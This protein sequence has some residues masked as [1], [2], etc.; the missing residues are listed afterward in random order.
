MTSHSRKASISGCLASTDCKTSTT[1]P[2]ACNHRTGVSTS[3]RRRI[4]EE[5]WVPT[6]NGCDLAGSGRRQTRLPRLCTR[7][8]E[9]TC[10]G[11]ESVVVGGERG[12]LRL[13]DLQ[14]ALLSH[15]ATSV[16]AAQHLGR[17][18]DG[19]RKPPGLFS[20]A[21]LTS[22]SAPS[23]GRRLTRLEVGYENRSRLWLRGSV[24]AQPEQLRDL[25]D[26]RH[27]GIAAGA[28]IFDTT[29]RG[30]FNRCRPVATP[31]RIS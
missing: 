26:Q 30:A 24:V 9:S 27:A 4:A 19:G 31:M 22:V 1:T 8:P 17:S 10:A 7:A 25:A 21:C 3:S 11:A 15:R 12:G 6:P 2:S 28:Q 5:S 14:Q 23:A 16:P 13:T 18:G 29:E 20:L